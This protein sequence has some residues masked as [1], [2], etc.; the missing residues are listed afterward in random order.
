[1]SHPSQT[2]RR[3]SYAEYARLISVSQGAMP[4]V[5]A[6]EQSQQRWALCHTD[7]AEHA[8]ASGLFAPN[9]QIN[10]KNCSFQL[11]S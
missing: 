1:M 3:D 11:C 7:I 6:H 2:I 5:A 8:Q 4:R 9:N 10:Y